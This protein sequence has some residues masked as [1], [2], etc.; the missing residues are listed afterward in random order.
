MA[1][2]V[3]DDGTEQVTE[4]EMQKQIPPKKF[5]ELLNKLDQAE[6]DME[7]LR[8]GMG[9][10]I[11]AV[12]EKYHLD[13]QILGWIR[14]LRRMSPEKLA[15]KLAHF[16]YLLDISGL[17]DR[18]KSAQRLGLGDE[19]PAADSGRAGG[20]VARLDEHRSAAGPA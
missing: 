9:G 19:A 3:G 20:K 12:T 6:D 4:R 18:A 5:K 8:G 15:D 11:T 16:E 7:E 2:K 14:K 10:A 17:S 1:E 13:K